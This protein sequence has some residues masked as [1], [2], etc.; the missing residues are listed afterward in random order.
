M[1]KFL[2]FYSNFASGCDRCVCP[3]THSFI[4]GELLEYD[5]CNYQVLVEVHRLT[6]ARGI[7]LGLELGL[8]VRLRHVRLVRRSRS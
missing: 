8:R 2:F 5:F 7:R 3:V 4:P 1:Q 6:A